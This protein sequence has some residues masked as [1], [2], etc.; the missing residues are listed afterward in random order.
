MVKLD[1]LVV[2]TREKAEPQTMACGRSYIQ[3]SSAM[4]VIMCVPGVART[5]RTYS[6]VQMWV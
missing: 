5:R 4:C 6:K 1:T 2:L 3:K